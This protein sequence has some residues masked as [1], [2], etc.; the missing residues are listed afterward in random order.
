MVREVRATLTDEQFAALE[1]MA[2]RL[3]WNLQQ[4]ASKLL[5][6][7]L[8]DYGS[9]RIVVDGP[10][11]RIGRVLAGVGKP[12]EEPERQS[13]VQED[14]HHANGVLQKDPFVAHQAAARRV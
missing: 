5:V 4:A 8:R 9:A 7:G 10:L 6:N 3:D 13:H 14:E 11:A 2:K 12:A 1:A